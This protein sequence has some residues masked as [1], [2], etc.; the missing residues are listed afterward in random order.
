MITVSEATSIILQN[1]W[2]GTHEEVSLL[3]S[4]DR[5]LAEDILADRDFPP[6]NRVTMDGISINHESFETGNRDYSVEGIQAAGMEQKSLS[7]SLN[8]IEVMT[9]A[10]VPQG[11]N[12]VIRYEDLK[13]EN[14]V[15][16]VMASKIRKGD[17][18]HVQGSDAKRGEILIQKGCLIS[19]AEI[20]LMASVGKSKVKVSTLPRTALISTG[21][22]LIDIEATPQLHQ[23]RKSNIYALAS[24]LSNFGLPCDGGSPFGG[25]GAVGCNFFHLEDNEDFIHRTLKNI[26]NDYDLIILSGGVSK[27]KFDLIPSTLESFGIKKHFHQVKQRPGKPLWFGSSGNKIVFALPGNPVSTFMCFHQYIKPWL[28]KSL[29]AE[30][31]S[32]KAILATDFTFDLPLTYFLQVKIKNEDGKILAEPIP[33]GGSG[34]FVNLKDADGFLELPEGIANF[35]KG[36][37][38]NFISFRK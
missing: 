28:L 8:C 10:M 16:K 1:L 12:T 22:E 19:S 5:I 35:K 14:G 17:S 13:I 36:E 24:A 34:D 15:A 3:Q 32:I 29:G 11:C 25:K 4:I 30:P 2:K 20:P 21:D 7:S 27:G 18:I 9:G 37:A 38:Y 33:G 31:S 6:F 26:L 23:I